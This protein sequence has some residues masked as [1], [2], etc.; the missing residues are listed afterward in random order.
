MNDKMWNNYFGSPDFASA[1]LVFAST[2]VTLYKG[3]N[4]RLL[5]Y[6][7]HLLHLGLET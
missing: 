3:D 1:W 4:L 6:S 2:L 5:Y 7:Q